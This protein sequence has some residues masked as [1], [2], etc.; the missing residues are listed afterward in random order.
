MLK[1]IVLILIGVVAS[2][3]FPPVGTFGS[4][5]YAYLKTKL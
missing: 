2:S 4:K 1:D 3:A 5:V